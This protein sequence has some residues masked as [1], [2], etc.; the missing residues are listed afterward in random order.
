[1]SKPTPPLHPTAAM[2]RPTLLVVG[3]GDV[4]LRVLERI[5]RR[6]RVFV[7]TSQPQRV[8]QLRKAGA[9]PLVGDLDEPAS[10]MR[11]AKL[12]DA[13][14]HLAPPPGAGRTDP[15]TQALIRTLARGGRVQ[16]LVYGST[17]GVYG[18]CGGAL[19]DETRTVAPTTDRARR[20]VHAETLL[21][22]WGRRA[23]VGITIL[24]IPGIYALDRE[25]GD[26]RERV[27]RGTP[28]LRAED[29]VHTN[30]VHADDLARGC[31]AALHHGLPQRVLHLSDD[32]QLTMG[33]YFDFVADR[34][35]LPRPPR[36][37]REEARQQLG[38]M[39]LSF[40]GESRRLVNA[41]MK[42]ELRLQ[43]RY[44]TVDEGLPAG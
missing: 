29:D 26:P 8:P 22:D 1:M 36:V 32:T 10:L 43:L 23:G 14:L 38:A 41:R 9:V 4:G 25:G 24:R 42:R 21:R 19:V 28:V 5:A 20:R 17:S 31:I 44:R 13:V 37:T 27:R 6:W 30:H 11:I 7:L 33:D 2:R 18:D 40:M 15:R 3:C 39:T 34:F 16:R 35:G 12:A